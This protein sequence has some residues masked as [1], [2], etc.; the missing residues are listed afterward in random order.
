MKG[1][2]FGL[3]N[4]K[5]ATVVGNLHEKHEKTSGKSFSSPNF[6]IPDGLHHVMH[7]EN[8]YKLNGKSRFAHAL[9]SVAAK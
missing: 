3:Q 1:M 5:I 6:K 9:V 2:L 4:E 8:N 7:G